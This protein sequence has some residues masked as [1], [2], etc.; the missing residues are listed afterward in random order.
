VIRERPGAW[1]AGRPFR[2][3]FRDSARDLFPELRAFVPRQR[4]NGK[5]DIEVD[6]GKLNLSVSAESPAS[7]IVFLDRTGIGS[8]AHLDAY[9]AKRAAGRLQDLVCYGDEHIRRAQQRTLSEFLRLPIAK[10][11]YGDPVSAEA[12]LRNLAESVSAG[13]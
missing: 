13:T 12:V 6:T 1:V 3:R 11:T 7:H 5:Y 4:P 9:C 2:I 8:G 10:L